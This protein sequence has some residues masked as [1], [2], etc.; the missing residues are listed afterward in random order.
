M[1]DFTR[2][3]EKIK[4]MEPKRRGIKFEYLF[5]DI[6]EEHGILYDRSYRNEDGTQQID[7]SL[8]INNRIFIAE[9]K[10]EK[11]KTLAAQKL[12]SFVAKVNSKIEGTLGIF[13]S[14][15]R[16]RAKTIQSARQGIKQNCIIIHG[17]ENILPI[18]RG[19]IPVAEFFWYA[20]E[21]ASTRGK[22]T[23]SVAEFLTS[24]RKNPVVDKWTELCSALLTE[25]DNSEFEW[26]LDDYL[27][28]IPD[29]P[30]RAIS[31]YPK[32][33]KRKLQTRI[34]YLLDS[35]IDDE[36]MKLR[37]QDALI[38]KLASIH[39]KEYAYEDILDRTKTISDL[40]EIT[41]EKIAD[42]A[43]KYLRANYGNYDQEN[44][45]SR[46]IE[47][48]YDHLSEEYTINLACAYAIIY[49]D[50][51]RKDT[52]E[53]KQMAARIFRDIDP[54]ERWHIIREEVK[55]SIKQLKKEDAPLNDDKTKGYVFRTIG[56][57]FERII[58][59]SEPKNLK[60]QLERWYNKA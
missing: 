53:Q 34:D 45:A 31:V 18:I 2:K 7:G 20:F 51:F 16:L 13:I 47:Y 44:D 23:T 42:K 48:V 8:K 50:S 26:M 37:L 22:V 11:P 46:V 12:L 35:I 32:L 29:L 59:E 4:A 25:E 41:A 10:W 38:K 43:I 19:E 1:K 5:Y 57:K 39:W 14:Y 52:F 15:E 3:F 54:D 56:R 49:C 9:S 60:R 27:D 36:E 17:E 55:D 40:D 28:H 21:Q 33:K 30:E 58:D 24:D 6:F